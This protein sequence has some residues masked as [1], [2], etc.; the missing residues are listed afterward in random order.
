VAEI[1]TF[2]ETTLVHVGKMRLGHG[3]FFEVMLGHSGQLIGWLHTHPDAR[4]SNGLCQSVC[5]VR[6]IDGAP[7]HD[8]VQVDP[9][10]LSPSLLCRTC[11]AHGDV[12]D[13]QWKPR[14][15]GK[16]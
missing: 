4:N 3:H 1:M 9:L 6:P 15:G 7:V 14:D 10:T 8:I 11:G 2:D 16:P 5:M 12:I 13:G